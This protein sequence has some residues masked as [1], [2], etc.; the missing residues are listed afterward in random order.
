M[1]QTQANQ[2]KIKLESRHK[3]P[4]SGL[5]PVSGN[6]QVG[7]YL[8]ISYTANAVFLEVY[9]LRQYIDSYVGGKDGVR[10]MEGTIQKIAKDCAATLRVRV[11]IEANIL[12]D[13]GDTL[14]LIA[15]A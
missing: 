15:A 11:Q 9:A 2:S 7:S 12:L 4:F 3:L 6:P 10:D 8:E 14:I 1:L 5:C 13:T